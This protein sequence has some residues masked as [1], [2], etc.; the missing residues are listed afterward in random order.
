MAKITVILHEP[1]IPQNTGNIIRLCA[2]SGAELHLVKPL[3]WGS[4]DDRKLRRSGLDYHEYTNLVIHETWADCRRYFGS[5]QIWAVETGS[6]KFYHQVDYPDD[7]ILLF[8]SETRGLP[9]SILDELGGA[10]IVRLP[11]RPQQR[12]LNL[13]NSVAIAVYEVWRQAGFAGGV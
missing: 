7:C 5:R 1:D 10:Q 13:S 3:G 11:M 2:N 4:M 6:D 12:S 9:Q 8:G